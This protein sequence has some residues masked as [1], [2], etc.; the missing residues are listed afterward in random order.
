[1]NGVIHTKRIYPYAVGSLRYPGRAVWIDPENAMDPESGEVARRPAQP[2][3]PYGYQ[4]YMMRL[5]IPTMANIVAARWV[6]RARFEAVDVD[7]S[8]ISL[9]SFQYFDADGS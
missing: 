8:S 1:M 6:V 2:G 3:S 5:E 4:S 9:Y 7:T